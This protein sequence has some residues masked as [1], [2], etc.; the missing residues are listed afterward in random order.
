MKM[1]IYLQESG[2]IIKKKEKAYT[3]IKMELLNL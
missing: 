1:A 2:K 3:D